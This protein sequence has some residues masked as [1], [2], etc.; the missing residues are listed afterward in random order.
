[1]SLAINLLSKKDVLNRFF[2]T[3]VEHYS[4]FISPEHK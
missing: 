2:N 1:M 4:T 3:M